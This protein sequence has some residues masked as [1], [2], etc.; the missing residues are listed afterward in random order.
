[1]KPDA[2]KPFRFDNILSEVP[3]LKRSGY[4]LSSYAFNPPLDSSNV[5]SG[6]LDQGGKY[7]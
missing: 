1:M 7:H 2:L 3:E 4:N 6:N 5:G